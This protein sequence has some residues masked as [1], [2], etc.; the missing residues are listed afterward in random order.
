MEN[1]AERTR[2]FVRDVCI[3]A[4][5]RF[6]D[7]ELDPALRAELQAAAREAGVFAPHVPPEY[8]GHGL[9][10]RGWA[11]VFEEAGYSLLGPQALN[12][13][14]PDEGNMRLLELVATS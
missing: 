6:T 11:P 14:A 7:G 10:I 3:P 2:A 12:C 5:A 9:D 13:A 8:G 4:E 1:L